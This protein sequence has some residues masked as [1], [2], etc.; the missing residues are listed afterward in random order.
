M[1]VAVRGLPREIEDC[2]Q[3]ARAIFR[4]DEIAET[5]VRNF[6]WQ[7]RQRDAGGTDFE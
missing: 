3:C 1:H 2:E 7:G 6:K 4:P 5:A